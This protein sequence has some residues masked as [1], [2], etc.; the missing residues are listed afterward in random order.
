MK[1]RTKLAI[2][3]VAAVISLAGFGLIT[4]ALSVDNV[5]AAATPGVE[6]SVSITG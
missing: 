1:I 5:M 6:F 4:N 2:F 3:V